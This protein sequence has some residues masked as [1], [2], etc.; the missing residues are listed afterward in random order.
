MILTK[1]GQSPCDTTLSSSVNLHVLLLFS[2]L[3]IILLKINLV[4]TLAFLKVLVLEKLLTY[5]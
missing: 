1:Y 2:S 3:L 4:F 5:Y